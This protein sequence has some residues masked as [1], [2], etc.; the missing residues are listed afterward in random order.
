M[1]ALDLLPY[2]EKETAPAGICEGRSA[3]TTFSE[4]KFRNIVKAATE[5]PDC[6]R[7]IEKPSGY[8]TDRIRHREDC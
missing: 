6:D 5:R 2:V 3:S 4:Q 8:I 7:T 1:I